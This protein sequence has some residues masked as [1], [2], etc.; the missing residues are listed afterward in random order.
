MVKHKKGKHTR[1]FL[2]QPDY[3]SSELGVHIKGFLSRYRVLANHLKNDSNN[4]QNQVESILL[5]FFWT[6]VGKQYLR[7]EHS[8]QALV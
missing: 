7:D 8:P 5:S 4:D 6:K 2:L 1:L 3:F